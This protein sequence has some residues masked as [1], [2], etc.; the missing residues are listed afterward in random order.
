MV[1]RNSRVLLFI[2][3]LCMAYSMTQA[4]TLIRESN[5]TNE[6]EKSWK[7]EWG[8]LTGVGVSNVLKPESNPTLKMPE[9]KGTY[10]VMYAARPEAQIGVFG[11]IGKTKSIFSFQIHFA[12]TMRA[13]PE[14]VFYSYNDDIKDVYKSTYLNGGTVS[15]LFCFK[16]VDK[17]KIGIGIEA[18]K[19]LVT[20]GVKNSDIGEYTEWYSSS[21][22][23]KLMLS[24]KVSPRVDINVYGRA[25]H[26]SE[27][28]K[29]N[30]MPDDISAGMT[31]GY[32]LCGKEV[33]YK[34]KI[35]EEKKVYRL[36]YNK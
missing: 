26:I 31:V 11:E 13:I 21:T 33:R 27:F 5:R 16:P 8:I 36:D 34:A 9:G 24:Y 14:P 1:A 19:F 3:L 20:E 15:A 25:G 7:M 6:I 23:L 28:D 4:Q 32:R 10:R 29:K 18:T 17:F 30:L 22:G 35:E 2:G 12:Y